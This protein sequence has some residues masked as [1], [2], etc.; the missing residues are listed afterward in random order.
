MV[1]IRR[2]EKEPITPGISLTAVETALGICS[3]WWDIVIEE[4]HMLY[5]MQN[6]LCSHSTR[7]GWIVAAGKARKYYL[8]LEKIWDAA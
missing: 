4:V 2:E 3:S 7:H 5:L 1:I 8:E 6:T